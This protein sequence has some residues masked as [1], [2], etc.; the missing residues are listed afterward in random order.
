[1]T[2]DVEDYDIGSLADNTCGSVTLYGDSGSSFTFN[3]D[4]DP[5]YTLSGLY[6][7]DMSFEGY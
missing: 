7:P 2:F 5:E 4:H 6:E 1:M 3:L